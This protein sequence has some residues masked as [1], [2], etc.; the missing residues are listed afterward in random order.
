MRVVKSRKREI[1]DELTVHEMPRVVEKICPSFYEVPTEEQ[2]KELA[3]RKVRGYK[4]KELSLT[5]RKK[6]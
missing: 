3:K 4:S 6:S 2:E 5:L 1:C